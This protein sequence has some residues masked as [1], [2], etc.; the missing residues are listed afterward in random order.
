MT[1]ENISFK[2]KYLNRGTQLKVFNYS[3]QENYLNIFPFSKMA[4]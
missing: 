3:S 4:K 2:S 1:S